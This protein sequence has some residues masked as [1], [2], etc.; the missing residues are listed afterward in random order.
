MIQFIIRQARVLIR[1]KEERRLFIMS[2][3]TPKIVIAAI[4]T[5]GR[6]YME[7]TQHGKLPISC[8]DG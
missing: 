4:P 8:Q 5:G 3:S 6:C 2:P 7:H 1:N